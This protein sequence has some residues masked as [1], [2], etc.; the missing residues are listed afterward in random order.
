MDAI[1]GLAPHGV[2][3]DNPL[4]ALCHPCRR[5]ARF[6]TGTRYFCFGAAPALA[7]TAALH[8]GAAPKQK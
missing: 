6:H 1:V 8:A 7:M 2:I 5:Q 4:R 3:A